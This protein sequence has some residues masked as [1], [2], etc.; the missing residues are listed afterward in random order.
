MNNPSI[1]FNRWWQSNSTYGSKIKNKKLIAC[2][3]ILCCLR[4][5]LLTNFTKLNL[6]F[7]SSMSNIYVSL[8]RRLYIS[9]WGRLYI[10]ALVLF[11]FFFK[12]TPKVWL[13]WY[14]YVLFMKP[15]FFNLKILSSFLGWIITTNSEDSVI[16]SSRFY[17]HWISQPQS[18]PFCYHHLR[19]PQTKWNH[20]IQIFLQYIYQQS[21][22][23]C[24]YITLI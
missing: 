19:L 11:G 6:G 23:C 13:G 21:Q 18:F 12:A 20:F 10:Y 17:S 4:K 1:F 8:W 22:S 7:A 14:V 15:F 3:F 5:K 2:I 9:R 24:I 16:S